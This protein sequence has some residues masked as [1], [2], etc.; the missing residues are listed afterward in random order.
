MPQWT[1]TTWN[2]QGDFTLETKKKMIASICGHGDVAVFIQEGGVAKDN[3]LDDWKVVGGSSVGAYN[4]RCTNYVLLSKNCVSTSMMITDKMGFVAIG[5][6]EAGRTAAAVDVGE[7]LFV[8]WH[9][10]SGDNNADTKDLLTRIDKNS[11]YA[12]K[13]K[14]V[15][16]GGDFNASPKDIKGLIS[17]TSFSNFKVVDVQN[18]GKPTHHG[19]KGDSE[20]DFFVVMGAESVLPNHKVKRLYD[21]GK[22]P[23][24]SDHWPVQ[25]TITF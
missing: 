23:T 6:G 10:Y 20:L 16:I 1:F 5:G 24:A 13:F 7:Y 3:P 17:R 19:A 2:T 4:E 8:S 14:Y 12:R 21:T 15:V 25:M 18:C 22:T 9:S 11:S